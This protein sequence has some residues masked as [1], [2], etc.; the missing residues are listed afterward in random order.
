MVEQLAKV[1]LDKWEVD[2]AIEA[3]KNSLQ[4]A[5]LITEL[6]TVKWSIENDDVQ[7]Y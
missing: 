1:G 3:K 7:S 5:K 6:S 4:K 2:K